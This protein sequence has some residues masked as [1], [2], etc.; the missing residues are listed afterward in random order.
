MLFFFTQEK[1]SII[2]SFPL[3]VGYHIPI[4]EISASMKIN[5]STI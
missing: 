1:L 2:K 3:N 4:I 5:L